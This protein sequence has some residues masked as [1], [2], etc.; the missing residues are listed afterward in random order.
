MKKS[1]KLVCHVVISNIVIH[2]LPTLQIS[3]GDIALF[4]KIYDGEPILTVF[5]ISVRMFNTVVSIKCMMWKVCR[6]A[7]LCRYWETI[8]YFKWQT[9]GSLGSF[10]PLTG[11]GLHRFFWNFQREELKARPNTK[12]NPPLIYRYTVKK[13]LPIFKSIAG[14]SLTKLS[15]AGNHLPINRLNNC[16]SQSGDFPRI[17]LFRG[18]TCL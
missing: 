13:G 16:L 7:T 14:M 11:W 2:T 17:F 4:E 18:C 9:Q 6:I 3:V 1:G 8:I 5:Q 10:R 15:L 12:F